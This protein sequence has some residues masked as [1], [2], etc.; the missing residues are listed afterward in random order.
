MAIDQSGLG[1]ASGDRS[2]VLLTELQAV[3]Q[4]IL[5]DEGSEGAPTLIATANGSAV[6]SSLE[7]LRRQCV[8]N[9]SDVAALKRSV[10]ALRGV[11]AGD[12]A[13]NGK[14]LVELR[15][16]VD[17]MTEVVARESDQVS[18]L[19]GAVEALRVGLAGSSAGNRQ[20]MAELRGSLDS[21]EASVGTVGSQV[22][23]TTAKLTKHVDATLLAIRAQVE[24]ALKQMG[25]QVEVA[26]AG[27]AG[28]VET[29]FTTMARQ[30]QEAFNAFGSQVALQLGRQSEAFDT[31]LEELLPQRT[32]QRIE[33]LET[34]LTEG[35]P[36]FSEEIQAGVQQTLLEVS[37]TFRLAEREHGNRM[38]ELHR[39]FNATARRLE[40]AMQ[41]RRR[42]EPI[43]GRD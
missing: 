6:A 43:I 38:S 4:R 11:V 13:A 36:R 20:Q 7:A 15:R 30:I 23:A 14:M 26:L 39:D 8:D 12:S 1:V 21:L 24:T 27:M 25:K 5:A 17:A 9:N 37:R 35:L 3:C 2:T 32:R 34:L 10:D 18:S 41:P 42:D 28:Q 31:L 29:A 40:A 22:E 16:T 19:V 33:E